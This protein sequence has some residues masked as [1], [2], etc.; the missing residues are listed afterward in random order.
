MGNVFF[1]FK[2]WGLGG[3][4]YVLQQKNMLPGE[5]KKLLP[6]PKT[7]PKKWFGTTTKKPNQRFL[8]AIKCHNFLFFWVWL[9]MDGFG[10]GNFWCISLRIDYFNFENFLGHICLHDNGWLIL[11]LPGG[12]LKSVTSQKIVY[13]LS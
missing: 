10:F 12:F 4:F 6:K 3:Y 9:L 5:Q 8:K 13:S 11:F 7:P 2:F 1:F